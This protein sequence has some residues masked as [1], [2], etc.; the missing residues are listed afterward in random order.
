MRD[1]IRKTKTSIFLT[2]VEEKLLLHGGVNGLVSDVNYQ[3]RNHS[4]NLFRSS[5]L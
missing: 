4:Y 3:L 5:Y 1:D 2:M